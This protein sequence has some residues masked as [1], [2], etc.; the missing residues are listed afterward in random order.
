MISIIGKNLH[1][2][3]D[4]Y[5]SDN[6][7]NRNDINLKYSGEIYEVWEVSSYVLY[8]MRQQSMREFIEQ[9][10]CEDAWWR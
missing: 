1:K 7:N 9:A 10:E 4:N 5:I 8:K 3:F 2:Y 6:T